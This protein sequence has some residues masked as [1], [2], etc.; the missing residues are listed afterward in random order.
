MRHASSGCT[1]SEMSW[2][3]AATWQLGS[4]QRGNPTHE[5][6]MVTVRYWEKH[7]LHT[8]WEQRW[9]ARLLRGKVSKQM[10]Q[11]MELSAESSTSSSFLAGEGA[12][13]EVNSSVFVGRDAAAAVDME[14]K[15][16]SHG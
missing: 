14:F 13:M 2:S 11:S 1:N 16:R 3:E 4:G 5:S 6:L 15:S 7:A 9:G 12:V 10:I 8:L